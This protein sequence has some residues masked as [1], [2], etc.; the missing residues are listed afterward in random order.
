[1]YR[2]SAWSLAAFIGA[3]GISL[4][5]ASA[6]A[7]MNDVQTFPDP[8]GD[9]SGELD[10]TATAITGSAAVGTLGVVNSRRKR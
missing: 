4:A 3:L 10:I 2:Q 1:M 8:A 5:S 9:A 7:A 6:A